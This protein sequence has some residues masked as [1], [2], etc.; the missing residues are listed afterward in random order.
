M[1]CILLLLMGCI[2]LRCSNGGQQSN[3]LQSISGQNVITIGATARFDGAQ[4]T[5]CV[6][7]HKYLTNLG[8]WTTGIKCS[9]HTSTRRG[10][11]E[12]LT[13]HGKEPK[14][15]RG[16]GLQPFSHDRA[17]GICPGKN[18]DGDCVR[19]LRKGDQGMNLIMQPRDEL[20]N[21]V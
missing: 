4:F 8:T 6:L 17:L 2:A 19:Y 14:Y 18:R 10:G 16:N 5:K 20:Q 7:C 21:L 1:E 15:G 11:L 12:L 13:Q 9:L 3:C